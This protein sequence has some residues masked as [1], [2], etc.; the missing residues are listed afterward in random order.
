MVTRDEVL[1]VLVGRYAEA[2]RPDRGRILDELVAITGHHRKHAARTLRGG[3]PTSRT[4]PRPRRRTYDDAVRQALVM[5]MV[6]EASDRICGKRLKELLPGMLDA[7]DRHGHLALDAVNRHGMPIDRNNHSKVESRSEHPLKPS[8]KRM[9]RARSHGRHPSEMS[10]Y[11]EHLHATRLRYAPA[12]R[13]SAGAKV[14]SPCRAWASSSSGLFGD[15]R[16]ICSK[17]KLATVYHV[18]E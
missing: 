18:L 13:K 15:V 14:T 6:W 5:V 11:G 1:S 16:R 8:R 17:L 7:M 9:L 4:G 12:S 3:T 2:S 10:R